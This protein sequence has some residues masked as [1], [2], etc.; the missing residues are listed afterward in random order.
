MTETE[1]ETEAFILRRA[2]TDQRARSERRMAIR[3][4]FVNGAFDALPPALAKFLHAVYEAKPQ[5]EL[6]LLWGSYSRGEESCQSLTIHHADDG[7]TDLLLRGPSDIDALIVTSKHI[8]IPRETAEYKVIS[9]GCANAA[10]LRLDTFRDVFQL[11]ADEFA[12][13][14]KQRRSDHMSCIIDAYKS[15]GVVLVA[16]A[17]ARQVMDEHSGDFDHNAVVRAAMEIRF[18]RMRRLSA[19]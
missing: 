7:K 10:H 15:S 14:L 12:I 4:A 3:R 13:Q 5:I 2:S 18:Q 1:I 16:R 11:R 19:S 6:L 17:A 9:G 8:Q